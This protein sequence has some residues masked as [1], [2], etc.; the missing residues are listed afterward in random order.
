MN[1][2][3]FLTGDLYDICARLRELDDGYRV[4]YNIK[5]GKFEVHNVR[6]KGSSYAFTVPYDALDARTVSYARYSSVA[7]LDKILKGFK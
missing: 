3:R 1:Y 6:Q 4:A 2:L 5:T 7:R